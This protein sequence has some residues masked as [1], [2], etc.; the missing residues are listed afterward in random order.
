MAGRDDDGGPGDRQDESFATLADPAAWP[1]A[2][3]QPADSPIQRVDTHAAAVFLGERHVLKIKRAVRFSFLDF[4]TADRRRAVCEAELRL[5]RRTAPEIYLRIGAIVRRGGGLALLDDAAAA[6]DDQIVDWLVVMRRFDEDGLLADVAKS[7]RLTDAICD[8]VARQVAALHRAEAPR[9]DLGGV[10][11]LQRTLDGALGEIHA[12][13]DGGILDAEQVAAAE[14]ALRAA[15]EAAREGIEA[16]RRDGF[17]R[18]VHGDLHLGNICLFGGQPRL[19]DCIEFNEEFAVIDILYDLAFLLMDLW[20]AGRPAQANRVLNFWLEDLHDMPGRLD[21][22]SLLPLYLA[23]RA[24]IRTHV[25]CSMAAVQQDAAAARSQ[26]ETAQAYLAELAAFLAPAQPVLLGIGGLSGTG[27]ST[28][29]RRLAPLLGRIPGAVVLRSDAIRKAMWGVAPTE[30]LPPE[31]YAAGQ[32]EAVYAELRR[33]AAAG[34]RA[35]QAVIADA[36]HARA[37]ERAA[38]EAVA[39]DC[40]TAFHGLW[41]DAPDSE[42]EDRLAARRGDVSDADSAV[43]H[44]QRGYDIGPL[45]WSRVATGGGIDAAVAAVA[46]ALPGGWLRVAPGMA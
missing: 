36:V 2:L 39:R 26:A 9:R 34:L 32:S 20:H 21:G 1:A 5:N 4:T 24:A 13:D 3:E 6:G 44:R 46:D 16:R 23:L 18:H 45:D 27:K 14:E 12:H 8:E 38:L 10:P 35:G 37:E 11:A 41:L 31:A 40:G 15:F 17:V 19:F 42:L 43:L 30:K 28:L 25:H 22:L 7:G 33:Q 29:A